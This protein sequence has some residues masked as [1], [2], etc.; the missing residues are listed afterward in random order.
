MARPDEVIIITDEECDPCLKL[1]QL[2]A[3][4]PLVRFLDLNAEE[5]DGLLG[6][7]ERVVVPLPIARF[8]EERKVCNLAS[9]GDRVLLVCGEESI[10]LKE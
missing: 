8:G 9:D 5:A 10:P 1:K 7:V 6:D 4:N 2:L 3:G